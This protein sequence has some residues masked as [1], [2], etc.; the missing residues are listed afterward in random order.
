MNPAESAPVEMPLSEGRR[1]A[2]VFHEPGAVFADI[3]RNGHWWIPLLIVTILSLGMITMIDKRVGVDRIMQRAF[4]TTPQLQQLTAE[5]KERA[6]EMQRKIIPIT[7]YAGGLVGPIIGYVVIAAVL[8]FFFNFLG[9]AELKFGS[10]LKVTCYG[11]MPPGVV[12]VLATLAVMMMKPP[13]EFDV[14]HPLA[15]NLGAFLPENSAKWLVSLGSSIDVFTFWTILL[16]AIGFSRASARKMETGKAF[17]L[18]ILPWLV[19]VLLK[20][21]WAAMFGG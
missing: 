9:G 18:I 19:Y 7:M 17:G 20:M 16:L 1:L 15:F 21:G 11:C 14:Q 13:E 2:G 10:A 3:A 5:Q 4:D 8:L 6:M 12:S